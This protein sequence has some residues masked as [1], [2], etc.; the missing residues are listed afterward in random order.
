MTGW[1]Y[2]S[3]GPRHLLQG[4]L[5]SPPR[6]QGL[7][8]SFDDGPSGN[9]LRIGELLAGSGVRALFFVLGDKARRHPEWLRELAAQGHLLGSHGERHERHTW[10]RAESV[11]ES[12]RRSQDA[13]RAAGLEPSGWF[14]P[15]YGAW[16]PWQNRLLKE[17]GLRA[18][19]WNLNPHDYAGI[20]AKT[21]RDRLLRYRRERSLALLHCSGNNEEQTW[22]CLQ[23]Y[24]PELLEAGLGRL[25]PMELLPGT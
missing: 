17:A 6:G 14:R 5:W 7:L 12:L 25:A 1:Y 22:L 4:G 15:P 23:R 9:S 10:L 3:G 16:W 13:I 18:L 11:R 21:I 24:L 20:P 2:R 8:A 19:Y